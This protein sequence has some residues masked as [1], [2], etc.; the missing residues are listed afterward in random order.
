M[1]GAQAKEVEGPGYRVRVK[2][3]TGGIVILVGVATARR[4]T[5]VLLGF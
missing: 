3:E 5:D 1:A 2:D 4:F